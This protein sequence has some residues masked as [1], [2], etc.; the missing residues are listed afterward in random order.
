MEVS[1]QMCRRKYTLEAKQSVVSQ[2]SFT[3]LWVDLEFDLEQEIFSISLKYKNG[4][5]GSEIS[6]LF[7]SI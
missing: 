2:L 7:T 1:I 4:R 6:H 5:K 3:P